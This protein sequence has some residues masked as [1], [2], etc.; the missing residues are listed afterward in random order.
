MWLQ[1]VTTMMSS[2][3]HDRDLQMSEFEL[4]G[5]MFLASLL[6]PSRKEMNGRLSSRFRPFLPEDFSRTNDLLSLSKLK[7][8]TS[9]SGTADCI[10]LKS[11][12]KLHWEAKLF[13]NHSKTLSNP[14][15]VW[16][17]CPSLSAYKPGINLES[18]WDQPGINLGSTNNSKWMLLKVSGS[19]TVN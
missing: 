11:C 3:K 19:A 6:A 4:T 2:V 8:W 5:S 10:H 14:L 17:N 15:L 7:T 16:N 18:T 1:R 13:Y 12:C 9:N